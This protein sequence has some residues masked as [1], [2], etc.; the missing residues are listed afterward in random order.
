MIP[1]LLHAIAKVVF[2]TARI[3]ALLDLTQSVVECYHYIQEMGKFASQV[4]KTCP[5]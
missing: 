2:I 3:M 4:S 1:R 5:L